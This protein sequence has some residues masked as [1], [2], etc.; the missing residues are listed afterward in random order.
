MYSEKLNQI[1]LKNFTPQEKQVEELP[2]NWRVYALKR[3]GDKRAFI[4]PN[5]GI[6]AIGGL[7][8][9]AN[10]GLEAWAL[11]GGGAGAYLYPLTRKFLLYLEREQRPI[12]CLSRPEWP[13]AARWL[14]LLGFKYLHHT[15][16]FLVWIREGD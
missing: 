13:A 5:A 4:A 11:L 16:G 1:H 3:P 8:D 7:E 15:K 12:R 10:G 6:C 14:K 2:H 9:R